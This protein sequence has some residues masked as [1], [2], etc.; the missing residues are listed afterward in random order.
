MSNRIANIR[1]IIDDL[2]EEYRP[3][4]WTALAACEVDDPANVW[5]SSE[6]TYLSNAKD[7][8]VRKSYYDFVSGV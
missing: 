3:L 5:Q 6:L 8:R 1:Y 4:A 2:A 7:W